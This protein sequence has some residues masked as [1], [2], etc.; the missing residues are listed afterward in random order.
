[1]KSLTAIL[2]CLLSGPVLLAGGPTH[3]HSGAVRAPARPAAPPPQAPPAPA[4]IPLFFEPVGAEDGRPAHAPAFLARTSQYSLTLRPT[5]AEIRPVAASPA[6]EDP[7]QPLVMRFEGTAAGPREVTPERAPG[8]VSYLVGSDA[9]A[10]RTGVPTYSRVRYLDVYPGVDVAYYG[11]DR[12]IEYDLIVAPGAD[13]A[14]VRLRFDGATL[15]LDA[16]GGLTVDRG[17]MS[18][19]LRAPVSYQRVH[20]RR[21]PVPSRYV[22]HADGAVGIEV[23]AYDRSRPLVIDPILSYSALLGGQG[24]DEAAAVAVDAAGNI[25]LAGTTASSNFPGT[26]G[27][28]AALDVFVA[29]LDPRGTGLLFAAYIGGSGLDEAR[30]LAIDAEGHAYVVGTTRSSNFPTRAAQQAALAGDADGF[31]F[32]LSTTGAGLVFSTYQGGTQFDEVNGVA[33]DPARNVYVAG[34]T[35]STDLPLVAAR[36]AASGGHMDG[37]VARYGAGGA[38]QFATYHGGSGLD[39]TTA[40]G[41][42]PA[43]NA[44]VTGATSSSDFPLLNQ[45]R[46]AN[47]GRVDAFVSRFTPSGALIFSTYVGG[48]G[49][50]AGQAVAVA[51][52]GASF[53]AGSTTSPDFPVVAPIQGAPGASSA[54]IRRRSAR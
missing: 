6:V 2:V 20:G 52:T 22:V 46:G 36:Q 5:S 41:V 26:T 28:A 15:G 19:V 48:T 39:T 23:G 13:P 31:L 49:F 18:L 10:W 29:K 25:Y 27:A 53:V 32:K 1:M 42:D 40:I 34:S 4:R 50:D 11:T 43:G 54:I 16:A 51:S 9:G 44:T 33:V 12:E 14:A 38:L 17:R 8:T 7:Q 47:A 21:T 24:L 30:G 3:D 45:A 37:F 35:R